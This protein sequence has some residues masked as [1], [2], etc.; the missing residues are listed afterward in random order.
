MIMEEA[1]QIADFLAGKSS[2]VDQGPDS[3]AVESLDFEQI[4]F[5]TNYGLLSPEH[6]V[7]IRTYSDDTDDQVLAE[8]QP[9][10]IIFYEPNQD[11]VRR[12]EV[13]RNSNP[14][15]GVRM[16]FMYY[17]MS[18]EE[19]KYLAGMRREKESF[20][21]LIKERGSMVIPIIEERRASSVGE[22]IIR[23]ISTRIAGGGRVATAEPS[24][25]IVDLREFWS[26][27]P[28][29]LHASNLRII[30][31]TLVVGDYIL[32]PEMCVERKSIPDLVS[33]FN[34]GRLYAQC[35]LM[36]VHYKQPILLL[37]FE[38]HKSFS[39]QIAGQLKSFA[40]PTGKYPMKA[41]SGP[42]SPGQAPAFASI[43]SKLV[44]LTLTFPRVR[45]IWSSSP[46]A[47]A[48]IFNDL[49]LNN[50]EPD[51]SKA[52]A[53]GAEDNA[54]AGAGWNLAA[55]KLIRSFPG[56]TAKNTRYVMG[57]VSSV[58]E[59]CALSLEQVQEVLGLEPG[60]ACW[61]FIHHGEKT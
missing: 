17:A 11:F 55:E 15:L 1:K 18:C 2:I 61:E 43:Q 4:Q 3:L 51:P 28:N 49:K 52:V 59:L 26:T 41:K 38:E 23:T 12:V 57:K 9:R 19:H 30:P 8:I 46:Y 44:L 27:L 58:K 42:G 31:A 29:L 20:E 39:L 37:E 45:I 47:T 40:K 60:K 33:S 7:I 56:I 6:T 54:E 16:Y 13:Y 36:S 53:V 35:E 24:Q 14:G 48:E 10:F 34:S 5:D 32:T 50:P 25:V 21:R 22:A